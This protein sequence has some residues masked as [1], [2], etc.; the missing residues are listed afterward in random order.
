MGHDI[1][2]H[3]SDIPA[4][5]SQR[6]GLRSF[7]FAFWML[8]TMEM[9]ERLAYYGMRVVVPIYI[10]QADEPGGLHFTAMQKVYTD[11]A[12]AK[13]F[14]KR[15]KDFAEAPPPAEWDGVFVATGK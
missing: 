15:C 10:M 14:I 11:D 13:T 12:A 9:W 7:P 6:R 1:D 8:N 4:T 2:S 5:T 3:G